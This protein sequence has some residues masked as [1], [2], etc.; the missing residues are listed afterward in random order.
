MALY[1]AVMDVNGVAEHMVRVDGADDAPAV[2]PA[3][4]GLLAQCGAFGWA[5]E[6]CVYVGDSPSDGA[7]AAAAGMMSVGCTWGAHSAEACQGSFDVLVDTP[8]RR[9]V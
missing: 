3:P 7:A 2:K 6:A 5:P 9:F 1:S 8:V 4:D